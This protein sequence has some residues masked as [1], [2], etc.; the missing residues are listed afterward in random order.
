MSNYASRISFPVVIKSTSMQVRVLTEKDRD[1]WNSFAASQKDP[2]I[3][4][5]YEWGQFKSRLGWSHFIVAVEDGGEIKAGISILSRELPLIKKSLFYAPRGP[6]VDLSKPEL[7]DALIDGVC[8]E[9]ALRN[10]LALKI[11]PEIDEADKKAVRSLQSKGFINKKKQVQPRSTFFIDLS[12]PVDELLMSFDEKTRYNIRL[13]EKKGVKV[14]EESN[15]SGLESF[16]KLYKD[17][18]R[19]DTFL[20]HPMSYYSKLRDILIEKGMANVF[21]AKFRGS[22]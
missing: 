10:A 7:F 14:V 11:D 1:L 18:C 16:Y 19:R 8:V 6:V 20:I 21:T 22:R 5:S 9:A 12:K 15:Q 13:A 4:Q 2:Q 17:T 3:L